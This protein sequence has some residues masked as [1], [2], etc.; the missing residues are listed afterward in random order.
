MK[1]INKQLFCAIIVITLSIA[2]SIPDY[3]APLI[4]KK[5]NPFN[6]PWNPRLD[7]MNDSSANNYKRYKDRRLQA[8]LNSNLVRDFN[9]ADFK[10]W[11]NFYENQSLVE[12]TTGEM[13]DNISNFVGKSV[14]LQSYINFKSSLVVKQL[15]LLDMKLKQLEVLD[16]AITEIKQHPNNISS[17]LG[18]NLIWKDNLDS[19]VL[20]TTANDLQYHLGYTSICELLDGDLKDRVTTKTLSSKPIHKPSLDNIYIPRNQHIGYEDHH[21]DK[22]I[23]EGGVELRNVD[24]NKI[25][26]ELEAEKSASFVEK[27]QVKETTERKTLKNKNT[28]KVEKKAHKK[29]QKK[30]HKVEKKVLKK[31]EETESELDK[32]S[33]VAER[34]MEKEELEEPAPY[35]ITDNRK[36]HKKS[37]KNRK[38]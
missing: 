37:R 25:K 34:E 4:V 32:N 12:R 22:V 18:S 9:L 24:I 36:K 23:P 19:V 17:N 10:I 6:Q 33:Y 14:G 8:T 2:F 20:E 38:F 21:S 13:V 16:N 11:L 5:D 29:V 27:S 7:N 31:E 35:D 28:K 3:E 26:S 1:L 15:A 30:A